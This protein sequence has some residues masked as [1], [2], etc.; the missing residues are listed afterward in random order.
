MLTR[1]VSQRR[2]TAPRACQIQS[3][4]FRALVRSVLL[5]GLVPSFL[6][7]CTGALI[8]PIPTLGEGTDPATS[9]TA[10]SP[11]DIKGARSCGAEGHKCGAKLAC[12]TAEDC[13]S[14]VCTLGKCEG[15][16]S[17]ARG[18]PGAGRNC[19]PGGD[20]DCCSSLAIPTTSFNRYNSAQHP[21]TV[22]G[23]SLDKFEVTVGRM[24]A[25]LT[26][27]EGNARQ[28]GPLVG[29]GAHPGIAGSGW[30]AE[31]NDMLPESMDDVNLFFGAACA[32]G[33]D[34]SQGGAPTYRPQPSEN[35]K[36]PANCTGWYLLNAFCAWDGGRLPT[37][38]EFQLALVGGEEQRLRAWPD[39]VLGRQA[40]TFENG[41]QLVSAFLAPA[42]ANGSAVGLHTFGEQRRHLTEQNV[43]DDG[44]SH[45]APVGSFPRGNGRW[46]HADLNG[47]IYELV[48]DESRPVDLQT[49]LPAPDTCINCANTNWP[50]L[51]ERNPSIVPFSVDE[52][53]DPAVVTDIAAWGKYYVGGARILQGG[54]WSH[55]GSIIN[56]QNHANVVRFKYPVMRTYEAVGGRCA[57]D[58]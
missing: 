25:F 21:A 55:L 30:R 34:A 18:G 27:I 48:L 47:N 52:G 37:E 22:K 24:R 23:F 36:K 10:S 58:F 16:P 57:R 35:D 3:P 9:S 39:S 2:F 46:G 38:A 28:F 56:S 14:N 33:G 31:W 44:D 8:D 15:I 5:A 1:A 45:I 42:N 4:F 43:A 32:A 50:L 20:E 26:S 54:S 13:V 7:G 40:L 29:A 6:L 53:A 17:C 49:G 41:Q 51:T 19:G 12:E 11:A